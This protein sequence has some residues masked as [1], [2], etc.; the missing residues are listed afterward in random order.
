MS[1]VLRVSHARTLALTLAAAGLFVAGGQSSFASPPARLAAAIDSLRVLSV[2]NCAGLWLTIQMWSGSPVHLRSVRLEDNVN[3]KI[4]TIDPF[5]PS[6]A[7]QVTVRVASIN[8]QLD[9]SASV[10]IKDEAG[11]TTRVPFVFIASKLDAAPASLAFGP[12]GS[13][14]RDTLE[15]TLTNPT[16]RAEVVRRIGL[17]TPV[18]RIIDPPL[19]PLTI[20]AQGSMTLLVEASAPPSGPFSVD[21]MEVDFACSRRRVPLRVATGDPCVMIG[22]LSFSTMPQGTSRTMQLRVSNEGGDT[23]TFANPFGGSVIEWRSSAFSIASSYLEALAA[24][25]LGRGEYLDVVVR[26]NATEPGH[27]ADTA[28]LWAS[29]RA[30]RDTSIWAAFVAPISGAPND[31]IATDALEAVHP[32]PTDGATTI[33]FTLARPGRATIE[34]FDERGARFATLLDAERSEGAHT[35]VLDAADL[36]PGV[37]HIRLDAGDVRRSR[38]FVRR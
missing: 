25:R 19:L 3:A 31:L 36:A 4:T 7:T 21:T 34:I 15:V 26:F 27:Y 29:T 12:V 37:Y 17:A 5:P 8:S 38:S 22:D 9:A 14:S 1:I 24:A 2:E 30:C 11:E 32:N 6:G 16:S 10:V 13:D 33:R 35:V 18:F 28:R 23:I 20:P